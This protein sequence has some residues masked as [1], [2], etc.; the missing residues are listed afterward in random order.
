MVKSEDVNGQ[1]GEDTYI[2]VQKTKRKDLLDSIYRVFEQFQAVF[3]KGLSKG[4]PHR[5]MGHEI[6]IDFE[7]NTT[8]MH[9]CT[10]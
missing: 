9:Y 8:L 7:P 3:T 4:V 6:K 5:R 2:K 1:F 10:E